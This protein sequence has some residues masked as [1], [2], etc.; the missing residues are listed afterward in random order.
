MT[1]AASMSGFMAWYFVY[2]LAELLILAL[3]AL[4]RRS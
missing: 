4:W 1:A 2:L 3:I